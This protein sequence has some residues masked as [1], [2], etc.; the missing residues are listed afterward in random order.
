MPRG[1]VAG[2]R[3]IQLSDNNSCLIF[4][5]PNRPLVCASLK[6][7]QEMCHGS[8]EQALIW[9][10]KLEADTALSADIPSRPRQK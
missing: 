7:S 1:K 6:P 2:E 3:C 8:R 5:D 10:E 4:D 9:L